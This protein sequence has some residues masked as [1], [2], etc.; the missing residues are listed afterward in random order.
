MTTILT[1]MHRARAILA[2]LFLSSASLWAQSDDATLINITTLAQLDAIR[3]DLNGDG[4]VDASASM[5]DSIS[6]ETAFSLARKG[7]ITCTGG[8]SGYELMNNL[9]FD[10]VGGSPSIWSE[11]CTDYACQTATAVDGDNADKVGWESIGYYNSSTD[12]APYTATFDGRGNTISNLYIN[13][14]TTFV[15]LFAFLGTGSNLRNLG[16]EGGSVT[17]TG[18]TG[19]LVGG[20]FGIISACYATG[21]VSGTINVGGLVGSSSNGTISDCY[22]TGVTTGTERNVGGLVGRNTATISACYATGDA[23]GTANYV[24]GLV[25]WNN[26]G[27]TISACYATGNATAP[28]S[29]VGGLVGRNIATI[30][31]CYATG[32]ARGT[33]QVGGLV[34]SNI[35]AISA[36][37]ATGDA[38]GD[39]GDVGGLVG[40]NDGGTVTS[41]YFDSDASNRTDSDDY[42]K[43]TAEFQ[44]PTA[45]GTS[46]DIYANWN[47]DVDNGQPIGVD[48]AT[49]TGDAAADDPWDFGTSMQYPALKVDFNVDGAPS[50]AE[51]G[52]QPRAV[53]AAPSALMAA[54]AANAAVTL[55]WDAP[56]SDGAP[57]TGYMIEYSLSADFSSPTTRITA[58]AATSHTV[59][60]LT[61]ATL[62][63]FRVAAVNAVGTGAY[64]PGAADDAVSATPAMVPATV[65][66]AP[67]ALTAAAANT[68]VTLSWDAPASD[69]GAPI[70]GYMIDYSLNADFASS[71]T[72]DASTLSYTVSSLANGTLYYFRVAAVNSVG[73]GAYYPGA[74]DAAVS[75]AAADNL[76]DVTTLEQLNA[77]RY[78]LNGEGVVSF[79]TASSLTGSPMFSDRAAVVTLMGADSIYAQAFMSGAFY[80]AADGAAAA[81]GAVAASTTYYYK[82]SSA[83]TSPYIGYELRNNLD[84]AGTKWENPTGGTFA[85]THETG[86]WA[87]IGYFNSSTDHASYTATF[88]GNDYTISNLYINRPSTNY[89]G[90]FGLLGTGS[91]LRNL[92]IE[93]GSVTGD[94]RVGGLVGRNLGT[95]SD[96]YATGAASG[97]NQVGGLVGENG[98]TIRACYATGN[99]S[100]AGNN[101]NVGGLVGRNGGTNGGTISDCY[102]TGDATGTI[103]VG[104]LVGHNY[105]AGATISDCYATGDATGTNQVGGLV[106]DNDGTISACYA[107]GTVTG[108]GNRVGGLVG[109]NTG[110]I[111]ACYATG[112][113][114]GTGHRVGGL[115][116]FNF[117]GTISACYATGNA[118]GT[119]NRVGGF[120]GWNVGTIRACYAT[121]DASGSSDVG[122]L[123]GSGTATN[124]YFDSD[125]SNRP[126]LDDYA[127]TT[128]E[129]QT[130]MAYAGIYANWNID[131]DNGQPIGVED[132]RAAGDAAADDPWDFGTNSQ[133]PVLRVDFNVNGTPTAFEFGGQGRAVPTAPAAPSTLTAAAANTAVTLSWTAASDGGAPITNYMIEYDTDMNFSSPPTTATTAA[134]ATSYT[135]SGLTNG[136]LYYF[137][138]AAVNAVGTGASATAVSATPAVPPLAISSISPTSGAVGETVM[139]TGTSF[140]TTA[141]DNT[142]TFLGHI[143]AAADNRSATVS[144]ATTTE[145]TVTVPP[146]AQTGPISVM[147]GTA[148]DTSDASFTVLI[149]PPDTDADGLID[150][151]TLAQ[152]DAIRYDLD[153]DGRPTSA[154]QTAWQA[155]FSAVV[156]V[157]DDAAA[158]DGSSSFTGYELRNSL[159]FEDADGN[160]TADDK[161]IWAE[162]A[163]GAGVPDA[164]AEGWAPIGGSFT[165]TF[166]GNNYAISNLYINRPSTSNVGLFGALG[167]GGNVRNLGIVG[168]SLTGDGQVGGLVGLNSSFGT[169]SAC[170][171][172]GNASGSTN[173]GG[174]VGRNFGGTIS[175]CYATGNATVTSG[176][177]GGLVGQNNYTISAC[178]STGDAS[179]SSLVGGLVGENRGTISA[180][181][182][183]GTASG[184]FFG[185]NIGGLVGQNNHTIIACYSTGD[186]SGSH[187]STG[188]LVG[189]NSG[190]VTNSYFDSDESNRPAAD[191]YDKTT[192]QLQTPTVYGTSTDIYANWNIDVDNAQ[193]IGVDDGTAAGDSDTDDPWD[194]GTNSQYP[195][196]RVDFNVDGIPRAFEFGGQGR[197]A[198]A[199]VPDA[200]SALMAAAA[201][202]AVTLSWAAP[203]SDGGAAITGY[204]IEYDTD[205]NFSSPPTTATTAAAATS[206]T[207]S[208]LTNGTLY[209]FR[210]AAVNAAGTGASAT[211]VSATPVASATVPDAP[212]VS[213]FTPEM[214]VVGAT[215]MIT[216]TG[217]S[218]T[219][220]D[221]TVTFLGEEANDADNVEAIVSTSP[222]PTAASLTVTVPP[223]AQTGKIQVEVNSVVAVSSDDFTVLTSV[224][225]TDTDADGL[226]DI[227][228]LTQLD[229]VRYDLNGDGAVSFTTADPLP[230][231]ADF[232]DRN[233]VLAVMG[234]TSAYA[235]EFASG[236]F[237]TA[238]DGTAAATGAVAANTTYYYKLSSAATSPYT[239]YELM[240]NLDF[241]DANGNGTADDKSIWAEGATAAGVPDAVAEGWKPIGDNSTRSDATRF[242]ATFE[243]NGHTISNLYINRPSTAH[244]GLFGDLGPRSNLRN[245]GIEGGSVTGDGFVGGLVGYNSGGTISAC[246]ATG[247]ASGSGSGNGIGGLMGTNLG[248][249]ISAC[250]ATGDA[251]GFRAVG[252]LVGSSNGTISAC[253]A[254][255]NVGVSTFYV[256]GLVG[257]ASDGS[258]I[259]ACYATGNVSGPLAG[260]LVGAK[261]NTG[262][263]VTNSYFDSTVSNRPVTDDYA[264][265]TAEL[266][267]P[268]AYGTAMDIYADWNID[269]DSGQPIGV[270]DGTE[271]G[272]AA[273]DNPWDFGTDM[274]YPALQVDFDRD[275]T[276][277]VAEFGNQPRTVLF[278]VS[279]FTPTSGVVGAT[280]TIRG[281]LFSATVTDNAV[282]FLGAEGDETD[283]VMATVS[284]ATASSLTVSVPPAAQTGKISVMV[285]AAADTSEMSFSVLDPDVLA[286]TGI[287]PTSG[288]VGETVMITGTGFSTTATENTVTFLGE[289]GDADNVEAIVS[290][291]PAPTAA[292]LSVSVPSTAQ[293]GKIS[294]MVGTAAD[295]SAASFTVTG[296]TPAPAA[297][298]V[299]NFSPLEGEVGIS[300]T[301]TGENFSDMPSAN[302]VK[303]GG[304]MA[305][306]PTSAS[307]TSL[308]VKVPSGAV[309]GSISVAVGGQTGT[310]SENFTVIVPAPAPAAPVVSSFSP[311][312]GE[313]D[314][315]VTITGVNFSATPSANEVRFGGVMAAEPTSASTTSL[316]VLVPSGAVTG[317]V[318]V[319]V[320]GQTG[321]SSE[322]FTV[323]VPA[324]APAAPVVSSFSPT[325]GEVDT[326]VTITGMNFSDVPSENDLRFGGVMAADPTSASTTS[327]V[328]LVPSG[329]RTGSISVAVGGQTGSSSES[330]TVTGTAPAPAAPVVSSFSPAE[331]EVG[332]SVTITGQ[333]FSATASEN[334]V[335]FGG[336]MA[337]APTSTSTTSLT[338]LVPSGARTGSISVAVGGQTGTSSTSFTVTAPAPAPDAPVVSSFSPLEGEV[339][340][341]V[342]IT[343]DNF[344][345]TASENEVRFGGVMAAAPTSAST[346]S[347]TVRVPS[348]AR[349]GSIS[350]A[351][352]GQTG[353]SSENFTVTGTTPVSPFSVPLSSEGDVRVYPNPTSGQLHFKGLLAGGR[354]V[355]DLYSLVGQKVLSSVVRAGDTM[356]ISTLSSAQY[357]L[358]LQAEG[359]ELMRTRLLVVR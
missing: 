95:I 203:T 270:D 18:A 228:A 230:A 330:F 286:I 226:I 98:G 111:R 154:G 353:T 232:S 256:G 355:C 8:C 243:G 275:G 180:C 338:I 210:V 234:D 120:V 339:D 37:Y 291:S 268:T 31:A 346:T 278:G 38:T 215:V 47:I 129:L 101:N 156:T 42:A 350:V 45:Y 34:G 223:A 176:R 1:H 222:A 159:D 247:D 192:T 58:A 326:E 299:L 288:P 221:N 87:L 199:T 114:T 91:N 174:L 177:V 242:T 265:T 61:N 109:E 166:H 332:T 231:A 150:I 313:V 7:S 152:L 62:Y 281:R 127:K 12:N 161:S 116:G 314:T 73:T 358:I 117:G 316:V 97:A 124:S 99:A 255:G 138:V 333:N 28:S 235:E 209:H 169:I 309:T 19:G 77:I 168:G 341:E 297:P 126:A 113:A 72:A 171:A 13:R 6:Y 163:S 303:F 227:T 10:N 207:V 325:E 148:A 132:G 284:A 229:A 233:D 4:M 131:V 264:K 136:T 135:V 312:E 79:T 172:T 276:A 100:G 181:Y 15:G 36:C 283:N 211:A 271:A 46:T 139:I 205:M 329:A 78:D 96:C 300:V 340:T 335:R 115:V 188:G 191:S 217:F 26:T 238:V 25:G 30:S 153:G 103:N 130:P 93:G 32:N 245:L 289:A 84:F 134:A 76:I 318:S 254:T 246:Y 64:Y 145:L 160:G 252:G 317:R 92:G 185:I 102:A 287:N 69:G 337:A 21:N 348:G 183:T 33:N 201:N 22:A 20:N 224:P 105:D 143:D 146:D 144:A 85:G 345:E 298:V 262:T 14:S 324:P 155:A 24:G 322:I 173:V 261:S 128:T 43:T 294:V 54:A 112:D 23:T 193:P 67:S 65:P 81:T 331:G 236:D 347:L 249:T 187:L 212:E 142:V 239:G 121:G 349:T 225:P 75:A 178:Y 218:T 253:Y 108:S 157:D 137:R 107:T 195:A 89:V 266:Q 296:T 202:A 259:S 334:D 301:I 63:Y 2:L 343:G 140:S 244:V 147:V 342:T 186:A 344:S 86:G 56:A 321:T 267:T 248:G 304:V 305:A 274:Q 104:G 51:F 311:T 40:R 260:G 282:V 258:T 290:T 16:I 88:D 44:T 269:V 257:V 319:A 310:S 295:T 250:Y 308:T 119:G 175:A 52:T 74:T 336:V 106:G 273:A 70:T 71:T 59:T 9:D 237:Y 49:M 39:S 320:G 162:G 292:S 57:I 359:R 251:S 29:R 149:S 170:Y 216:G 5:A 307:T 164:V 3:Y 263:V 241:E 53:P 285:G 214:G 35:G 213:S 17:G 82:L 323:T 179:G 197:P 219:A 357:I 293:T 204:M 41:S 220:A 208:G 133:Y 165:A 315:E 206:Y 118:T 356:D 198:P 189:D 184:G 11:N 125:E 190:T 240:N 351:V 80:T 90:L 122:G 66:A 302:D 55:S 60:G 27:G 158:H 327:L 68:A 50:V 280:V 277:S 200:P 141:A 83:A 123:V 151:T 194:F 94:D 110:T 354:Y 48:D 196:L 328:V 306:E 182:A 279:S 352:G 167:P 272:D